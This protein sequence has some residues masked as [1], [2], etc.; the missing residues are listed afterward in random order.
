M[1]GFATLLPR[2]LIE[3]KLAFIS[4][5]SVSTLHN[6]CAVHRGMFSTPGVIMST[7]G[8]TVSTPGGYR[9]YTGGIS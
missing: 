8:D 3:I 7:V 4:R 2:K 1:V 5:T 6:V 9:E